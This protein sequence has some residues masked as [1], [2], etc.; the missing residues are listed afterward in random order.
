MKNLLNTIQTYVNRLIDDRKKELLKTGYS[1][2]SK[3]IYIKDRD[4]IVLKSMVKTTNSTEI[5]FLSLKKE[6]YYQLQNKC[7]TIEVFERNCYRSIQIKKYELKVNSLIS[8]G[9]FRNRKRKTFRYFINKQ[10]S[11]S[12][13]YHLT[14]YDVRI[15]S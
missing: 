14:T 6:I 13:I 7:I 10:V 5:E 9:G 3:N 1:S 12:N 4:V 15:A 2:L 11:P 8:T